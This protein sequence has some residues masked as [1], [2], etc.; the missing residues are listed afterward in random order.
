MNVIEAYRGELELVF[1]EAAAEIASFPAHLSEFGLKLLAR[2]NPLSNGGGTNSISYLLPYWMKEQTSGS[3]VLCR[4]LSVGN[5]FAMLHF[6]LLDDAMDT[7]PVTAE[8][9]WIRSSLALGQLLQARFQQRYSRHFSADSEL[10]AYYRAYVENWASA[11]SLEGR[12]PADPR[13]PARLARKSAPVK[14][15]AAGM[16]LLSDG[17]ERIRTTEEAIDLALATLQL[18]DDWA[19]WRDDLADENCSAFLTLARER[20]SASQDVPLDE[21]TVKQAIYRYGCLDALADIVEGYGRRLKELPDVPPKVTAFH[22]SI[23]AGIREDAR[24]AEEWTTNLAL[25]GGF[26]VILLNHSAK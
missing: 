9:G 15:C 10:W 12:Q 6:F 23:A 4:D 17:Q 8:K 21:R 7:D 1:E 20:L 14:L 25:N 2:A 24:A 16:L 3:D 22:D 5:I 11:V 18:S 13:D 26:S 19:D